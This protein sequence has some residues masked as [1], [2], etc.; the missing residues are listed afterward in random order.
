MGAHS[1]VVESGLHPKPSESLETR[2]LRHTEDICRSMMSAV[3]ASLD[4]IH[5][6]ENSAVDRLEAYWPAEPLL[7]RQ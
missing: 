4:R 2:V 5:E 6:A 1:N 3:K 7:T